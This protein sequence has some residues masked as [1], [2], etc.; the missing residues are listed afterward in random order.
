MSTKS[1][2]AEFV[3]WGFPY[4]DFW[5]DSQIQSAITGGLPR[6]QVVLRKLP[7]G[8]STITFPVGG[9]SGPPTLEGDP[10]ILQFPLV[11]SFGCVEGMWMDLWVGENQQPQKWGTL[12]ISE[13]D[14]SGSN[15][16]VKAKP[17]DVTPTGLQ[18]TKDFGGG[19]PWVS[20]EGTQFFL[21]LPRSIS[22]EKPKRLFHFF[23]DAGMTANPVSLGPNDSLLSFPFEP[24]ITDFQTQLSQEVEIRGGIASSSGFT[25]TC[26]YEGRRGNTGP[27]EDPLPRRCDATQNIEVLLG[28]NKHTWGS[29]R[30]LNPESGNGG[31]AYRSTSTVDGVRRLTFDLPKGGTVP[32]LTSHSTGTTAYWRQAMSFFWGNDSTDYAFAST[33]VATDV[34]SLNV[35]VDVGMPSGFAG[36]VSYLVVKDAFGSAPTQNP[37]RGAEPWTTPPAGVGRRVRLWVIDADEE[38]PFLT[39]ERIFDGY[40][41]DWSDANANTQINFAL[42]DVLSWVRSRRLRSGWKARTEFGQNTFNE[43]YRIMERG[44][45]VP[46]PALHANRP[47]DLQFE[48][49]FWEDTGDVEE[50]GLVPSRI[51]PQWV[52]MGGYAFPQ[53]RLME[54]GGTARRFAV[55]QMI[56]PE[57]DFTKSF[58]DWNQDAFDALNLYDYDELN[59]KTAAFAIR[60]LGIAL[61]DDEEDFDWDS[62]YDLEE[63]VDRIAFTN[64]TSLLAGDIGSRNSWVRV[65]D[66]INLPHGYLQL[67]N[68]PFFDWLGFNAIDGLPADRKRVYE[69]AQDVSVDFERRKSSRVACVRFATIAYSML[70]RKIVR[71]YLQEAEPIHIFFSSDDSPNSPFNVTKGLNEADI[72]TGNT[73]RTGRTQAT[74]TCQITVAELI[75]QVLTSTGSYRYLNVGQAD[76]HA[77]RVLPGTN[78][79][80]DTIPAELGLA[81]PLPL[82]DTEQILNYRFVP[83]TNPQA[84]GYKTV[85][86]GGLPGVRLGDVWLENVVYKWEDSNDPA[87]WLTQNILQPLGLALVCTPE[88]KIQV[89]TMDSFDEALIDPITG[90]FKTEGVLTAN[91]LHSPTPTQTPVVSLSQR[92]TEIIQSLVIEHKDGLQR[93]STE[94]PNTVTPDNCGVPV[95]RYETGTIK[96]IARNED[97]GKYI[98]PFVRNANLQNRAEGP[99]TPFLNIRSLI[100]QPPYYFH[101]RVPGNLPYLTNAEVL[102]TMRTEKINRWQ[103]QRPEIYLEVAPWWE[104]TQAMTAG[105]H[106]LVDLPNVPNIDG[107]RGITGVV[108]VLSVQRDIQTGSRILQGR[109]VAQSPPIPP[110]FSNLWQPTFVADVDQTGLTSTQ[111]RI[112]VLDRLEWSRILQALGINDLN[113][114]SPVSRIDG[115][116]VRATDAWF[117]P[118]ETLTVSGIT[119]LQPNNRTFVLNFTT[120]PSGTIGHVIYDLWSAQATTP[121]ANLA[122]AGAFN[123]PIWRYS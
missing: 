109:V 18:F 30:I 20:T 92:S 36:G 94:F 73:R 11:R 28:Q 66:K 19:S 53:S 27:S 7:I 83:Y 46:F 72:G 51:F 75:L 112:F 4:T 8:G 95:T 103:I 21:Y 37:P 59:A 85:L 88:G 50:D 10:V 115:A 61:P 57:L 65:M 120:T 24:V 70:A 78:G 86:E 93:Y 55:T 56:T 16:I 110:T 99:G 5:T 14:I 58:L 108:L 2:V 117:T 42:I 45:D 60:K 48:L 69:L 35:P 22:T 17:L 44:R 113:A 122:I 29:R 77:P 68:K 97:R 38:N 1:L 100:E 123:N 102:S 62:T 114:A 98:V 119:D 81:I 25:F 71:N 13:V 84:R 26:L 105:T 118:I 89:R 90:G 54:L 67:P 23:Q 15:V 74:M 106:I 91:D 9:P 43:A 41:D 33:P 63:G 76:R 52:S 64:G 96:L 3:G 104:G 82:V 111:L 121:K 34:N 32:V 107:S 49:E 101:R 6:D 31:I 116:S 47:F 87:G 12:I 80:W 39:A 79:P 40:I